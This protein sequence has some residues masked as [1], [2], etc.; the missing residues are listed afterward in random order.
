MWPTE[1]KFESKKKV[2]VNSKIKNKYNHSSENNSNCSENS[3]CSGNLVVRSEMMRNPKPLRIPARYVPLRT[4]KRY[5][6][7]AETSMGKQAGRSR[8]IWKASKND[9]G[10]GCSKVEIICNRET[11]TSGEQTWAY[12]PLLLPEIGTLTGWRVPLPTVKLHS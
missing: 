9:K 5:W 2:T 4:I 12:R 8:E 10:H 6:W 7:N 11:S 3:N 1:Y